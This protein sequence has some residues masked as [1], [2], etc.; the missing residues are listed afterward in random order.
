VVNAEHTLLLD[1][2][3]YGDIEAG[4]TILRGHIRRTRTESALHPEIFD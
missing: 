4:Q 1:A 3:E 2:V